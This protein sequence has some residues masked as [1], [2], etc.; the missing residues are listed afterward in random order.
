MTT[1]VKAISDLIALLLQALRLSAILPATVFVA[2]N[3]VFVLPQFEGTK[4][5]ETLQRDNSSFVWN[6]LA[7]VTILLIGYTLAALNIPIIRFFEGY[8]LLANP[9]GRRLRLSNVRRIEYLQSRVKLLNADIQ[10]WRKREKNA[11]SSQDKER[12]RAERQRCELERNGLADRL[13]WT[14]PQ[15]QT[16]RTL[17][18]RLGNVIAAAEEYSGHLYKMD[19]VTLWPYLTPILTKEG[20]APFIEK[21]KATFDFLLNMT[22]LTLLFGVE[23]AYLEVLFNGFH[24]R[25][26]ALRLGLAI[27]IAF[28]FY[29]LSIQGALG[30]GITIRTAFVLYRE[31]LRKRLG[32]KPPRKYTQ[33]CVLWNKASLFLREMDT[34]QGDLIFSYAPEKQAKPESSQPT[35]AKTGES[36]PNQGGTP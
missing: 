8:P 32:L 4:L 2:L 26:V 5:Y 11:V 34:I 24:W 17:P 21:E 18:T 35:K 36:R 28:G 13:S 16:W 20:Y 22:V 30:W 15:H 14:Y 7:V 33:E 3:A 31:H 27:A 1:F 29:L 25:P 19:S 6:S 12:A 9:L 23:L 10:M